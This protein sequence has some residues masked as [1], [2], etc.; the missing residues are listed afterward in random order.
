MAMRPPEQAEREKK[1]CAAASAHTWNHQSFFIS[2]KMFG[3]YCPIGFIAGFSFMF[4][5]NILHAR[6]KR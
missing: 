5:T 4:F 1:I 6:P 2:I 3:D